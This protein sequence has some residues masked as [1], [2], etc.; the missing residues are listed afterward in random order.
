MSSGSVIILISVQMDSTTTSLSKV[1]RSLTNYTGKNVAQ[2]TSKQSFTVRGNGIFSPI[3]FY[4]E[5]QPVSKPV[6]IDMTTF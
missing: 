1:A 3:S 5:L 4:I 2:H 6:H